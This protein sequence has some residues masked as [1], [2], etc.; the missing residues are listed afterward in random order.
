MKAEA[1]VTLSPASLTAIA[2]HSC[3]ELLEPLL[4]RDING[5]SA[6][7]GR[8]CRLVLSSL[9]RR[10][11]GKSMSFDPT[12]FTISGCECIYGA[13]IALFRTFPDRDVLHRS[14]K[15]RR[16]YSATTVSQWET[17]TA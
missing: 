6:L 9:P 8:F 1:A 17:T 5:C 7:P 15:I 2:S 14:D 16:H 11:N 13:I 10:E 4:G 12:I 3:C